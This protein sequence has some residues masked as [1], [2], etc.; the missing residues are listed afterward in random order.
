M[1]KRI[2]KTSLILI[3]SV[4]TAFVVQAQERIVGGVKADLHEYPWQAALVSASGDGYCG[5]SV[6]SNQWILTAAHCLEGEDESSVFVRVGSED[7]YAEGGATYS[8]SEVIVH[9]DYADVATGSDIALIK[10]SEPLK[11][12]HNVQPIA[13]M[14]P[15]QDYLQE[16]GT[17]A[18][19]SGWG[20]L[21]SG[22]P[23]AGILQ[24]VELPIVSNRVACGVDQDENGN[25]GAYSCDEV[26]TTMICAGYLGLGG[27]DACQGDSGGPLVVRNA[28]D[29]NW[30]LVGA[31]SWGNGCADPDFPGIWSR[32][33]YFY[34]WVNDYAGI[35]NEDNDWV[36][37]DYGCTD[38]LACNFDSSALYDDGG[39]LELDECGECGGDGPEAGYDCAGFCTGTEFTVSMSDAYGDGWNG[40]ELSIGESTVSLYSD[41]L[42]AAD[43]CLDMSECHMI[44][45]TAGEFPDEISWTFGNHS[46]GAPYLG[47]VGECGD[48]LLDPF[49]CQKGPQDFIDSLFT[50]FDTACFSP[51]HGSWA[52]AFSSEDDDQPQIDSFETY[53]HFEGINTFTVT[54][55]SA[56]EHETDFGSYLFEGNVL[57]LL[58][59]EER[60]EPYEYTLEGDSLTLNGLEDDISY[61]LTSVET[62]KGCLNP[63]SPDY[64]SDANLGDGCSMVG[65]MNWMALN[66]DPYANEEDGSCIFNPSDSTGFQNP[67]VR[68]YISHFDTARRGG[69]FFCPSP[70]QGSWEVTSF[71]EDGVN[72]LDDNVQMFIHF[73]YMSSLTLSVV[74]PLESFSEHGTY[75][76]NKDTLMLNFMEDSAEWYGVNFYEDSTVLTGLYENITI[77]LVKGEEPH[78]CDDPNRPMPLDMLNTA[79]DPCYM[80]GCMDVY[81]MNYNSFASEDDGSCFYD[82]N[83]TTGYYNPCDYGGY[84][85][86]NDSTYYDGNYPTDM[87]DHDDCTLK[88]CTDDY[89]MNYNPYATQED[90][91]CFYDHHDTTDYHHPCEDD[92]SSY[93]DSLDYQNNFPCHSPIE[94]PWNL[95]SMLENGYEQMDSLSMSV[96]FTGDQTFTLIEHTEDDIYYDHGSYSLHQDTLV[97]DFQDDSAEWYD[98]HQSFDTLILTALYEDFV[99]V[100]VKD[101]QDCVNNQY[102]EYGNQ[103]DS[104]HTDD[105]ALKGCMDYHAMNFNPQATYND[106]GSCI[107]S[108]IDTLGNQHLHQQLAQLQYELDLAYDNILYLENQLFGDCQSSYDRP[109]DMNEGW[110]MIGY[111]CTNPVDVTEVFSAIKDLIVIVKDGAGNPYLPEFGYNGLGDLHYSQGYQ[112]KLTDDVPGF[113]LCPAPDDS[114]QD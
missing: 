81:A 30:L 46:G 104:L 57:Y 39:C 29:T 38:S 98:L 52:L 85:V 109:M 95:V 87:T 80:P 37:S 111:T 14:S 53:I 21:S 110:S 78:N 55:I 58:F 5:A 50:P 23:S 44:E 16:V 82:H 63:D 27:K 11:F 96:H 10:L 41:S 25:S 74:S 101:D 93:Y 67:C 36:Y 56:Y 105:C 73:E 83:D 17:L 49:T 99:L 24:A 4:L 89:A 54:S 94:G 1:K 15:E 97:L 12:T 34:D 51:L 77:V 90:G 75:M 70:I 26:D 71:I 60:V 114:N 35:Y 3:L 7:P 86:Y 59:D 22:G 68:D 28:S 45:V 66:F 92:Y 62:I 31:T 33:S 103:N 69:H 48:S 19:T 113:I 32:V 79:E 61:I 88:G 18:L 91:S 6:I 8:V 20:S 64:V 47:R 40:A 2:Q 107:Y 76:F 72:D 43:I 108:P 100:L 84:P 102:P 9:P 65:C 112:I 106:D 13:I 42:G